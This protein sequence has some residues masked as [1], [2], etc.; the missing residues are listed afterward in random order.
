M[1]RYD[2]FYE[3]PVGR[4]GIR[5]QD[6]CLAE[7]S[8]LRQKAYA[9]SRQQTPAPI[10][11]VVTDTLDAYFSSVTVSSAFEFS[12]AGTKFQKRV[13][14]ALQEIPSGTVKTYGELAKEL[15]T[16]SRAI[17]QACKRN[18]ISILIPCHR[19]VASHGIGGYM[20][21]PRKVHIKHWL[22]QHENTH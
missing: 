10:L 19:I 7:I 6:D 4:L 3:S 9:A 20:G 12:L 22:L 5:L 17:G 18:P 2:A 8:W 1:E 21:D 14:Q 16:S 13:W 15:G 11:R